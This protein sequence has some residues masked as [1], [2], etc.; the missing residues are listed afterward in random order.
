MIKNKGEKM[1]KALFVVMMMLVAAPAM[2]QGAGDWKY[3][4]TPYLWGSNLDGTIGANGVS[5][6]AD[7]SFGDIVSNVDTGFMGVFEAQNSNGWGFHADLQY[8]NLKSSFDLPA[9]VLTAEVDQLNIEGSVSYALAEMQGVDLFV[10]GRYYDI[11]NDIELVGVARTAK[12]QTWTDPIIGARY[13]MPI[14]QKI[15]VILRGDVGGF[16]VGSDMAYVLQASLAYNFTPTVAGVIGYRYMDVDY[17]DGEF[18]YDVT[19][20]GL[21]LGV[22][23]K[24]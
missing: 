9:T 21:G 10:G 8:I 7:A 18:V 3:S 1:K 15:D 12:S 20:S 11:K 14:N 2:A 4:F 22:T 19:Q 23:F 17:D 13:V 5:A 6:E 16:S 24:F